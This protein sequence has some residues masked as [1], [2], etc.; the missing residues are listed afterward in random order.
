MEKLI[1]IKGL[2]I[3]G[4]RIIFPIIS[5]YNNILVYKDANLNKIIFFD[6]VNNVYLYP[7]FD[8]KLG[9][10]NNSITLRNDN[11]FLTGNGKV[12]IFNMS[13]NLRLDRTINSLK[14]ITR[15]EVSTD[16]DIIL[17]HN[18]SS[19][20]KLINLIT[21]EEKDIIREIGDGEPTLINDYIYTSELLSGKIM[22]HDKYYNTLLRRD[23]A[24]PMTYGGNSIYSYKRLNDTINYK[25]FNKLTNESMI[26]DMSETFERTIPALTK[27]YDDLLIFQHYS[28]TP[29]KEIFLYRINFNNKSFDKI[30][31]FTVLSWY[32][33]SVDIFILQE[34]KNTYTIYSTKGD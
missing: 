20:S 10:V 4:G 5:L 26:V 30:G 24:F 28:S 14:K 31:E 19:I 27:L 9:K 6:I 3:D 21:N 22:V 18:N 29:E 7:N 15:C 32:C 34:D 33:I 2:N 8:P 1:T 17:I 25:I 11:L 16:G 23:S 12:K 13:D